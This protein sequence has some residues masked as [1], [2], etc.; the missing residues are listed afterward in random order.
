[1]D[2]PGKEH[3]KEYIRSLYRRNIRPR[4][5]ASALIA[6]YDF[7]NGIRDSGKT[8]LEEITKNDIEVF[9]ALCLDVFVLGVF[10]VPIKG[11][12]THRNHVSMQETQACYFPGSSAC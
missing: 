8:R 7:L 5:Y 6:I 3:V 10:R 1:M 9:I 2:L 4:T 12:I 11:I